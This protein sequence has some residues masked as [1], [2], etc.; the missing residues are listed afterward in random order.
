[1]TTYKLVFITNLMHSSFILYYMYYIKYFDMFRA[2][3]CSSSGGQN[4][5]LQHLVSSPTVSD[6]AVHRLRA[7]SV[8]SQPVHCTVEVFN[9]M[10]ILQNK[11]I[12]HQVGNKNK[13]ILWCTV[14]KTS[15]YGNVCLFLIISRRILVIMRHG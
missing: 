10:H 2:M 12:V 15:N 6:R 3:L 14:R 13:F 7:D 8:R 11:G 5:I 4:C 9:V 1:M